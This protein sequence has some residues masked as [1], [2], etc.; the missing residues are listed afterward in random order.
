MFKCSSR[1]IISVGIFVASQGTHYCL[2]C[3]NGCYNGCASEGVDQA[4][5]ILLD[6]D[7]QLPCREFRVFINC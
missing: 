7:P 4:P 6:S 5:V 1:V 2:C 3:Y